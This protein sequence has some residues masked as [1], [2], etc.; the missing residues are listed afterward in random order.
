MADTNPIQSLQRPTESAYQPLSGYAVA[1]ALCAGIFAVVVLSLLVF[2]MISGRMALDSW[3]LALPLAGIVLSA[4]GRSH[5]RNS[6]GTR[7]GLKMASL[8]WWV[9]VLGGTGF[10]AYLYA[11][12]LA[13]EYESGRF[14]DQMFKDLQ[15]GDLQS[16]FRNHCLPPD[17]RNR[18]EA[19]APEAEFEAAYAG[20]GYTPFR[21]HELV[22]KFIRNGKDVEF[23]RVKT[24]ESGQEANGIYIIHNY[25]IRCP[26]GTYD[27]GV[28][29]I[30]AETKKGGKQLWQIPLRR[31][32][33]ISSLTPVE[34]S[35]YGQLL[36]EM[37][38][39]AAGVVRAWTESFS[40][41][42]YAWAQSLTTS[43]THRT[44][45]VEK[46][47]YLSALGGGPGVLFPA[48]PAMLPP[49]RAA[50]WEE[51][52]KSIEKS[53]RLT[54]D[55]LFF[56]ELAAAGF[57]RSDDTGTQLSE[58]KMNRLR[59][60][61]RNGVLQPNDARNVQL[62]A[63]P[64][65][66]PMI[67]VTP[68]RVTFTETIDFHKGS[69]AQIRCLVTVECTDPEFLAAVQSLR[70]QGLNAKVDKTLV[71]PS[72]PTH[73]WRVASLRTDGELVQPSGPGG[74]G[75]PLPNSR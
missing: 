14:T 52:R 48:G 65:L 27:L 4:I 74:I 73:H 50:A 51:K 53:G 7:S 42:R 43:G 10:V 20:A 39:E 64:P 28:K 12:S 5:I 3:L 35:K 30:A 45:L 33:G 71:L 66:M 1:A 41:Q 2:S 69:P 17:E 29:A 44:P 49:D 24:R 21:N 37:P 40:K 57:F 68:E 47:K 11:N 58:E 60:Y 18:A 8:S 63:T 32:P 70:S 23:E 61:W 72:L 36:E 19:T 13:L 38:E 56:E 25:R 67:M 6:E 15:K 62:G 9:C 54:V 34:I 46:L 16:A 22:R 26:E 75:M 31:E 59:D 55:D